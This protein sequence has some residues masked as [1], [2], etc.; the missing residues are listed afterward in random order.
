MTTWLTS[1]IRPNATS[2]N[3]TDVGFAWMFG[4]SAL[5]WS[6]TA[7]VLPATDPSSSVKVTVAFDVPAV[8]GRNV[9]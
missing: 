9:I 6:A 7:C 3:D 4:S 1:V 8:V 5:P 2:G